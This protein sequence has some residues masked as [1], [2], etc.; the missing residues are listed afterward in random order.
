M[1][2]LI[3]RLVSR[4]TGTDDGRPKDAYPYVYVEHDGS[5]RELNGDERTDLEADDKGPDRPYVK[6]RYGKR[7]GR[8]DLSGYLRRWQLP[9]RVRVYPA[10]LNLGR[11]ERE[12]GADR[13]DPARPAASSGRDD[14][15][16]DVR[17]AQ[18]PI[19]L[20][21]GASYQ[22]AFASVEEFLAYIE[23]MDVL[24]GDVDAFDA[25]G[26]RLL[27]AADSATDG[28]RVT[29]LR[30]DPDFLHYA[31]AASLSLARPDVA[32]TLGP[33]AD[34]ADLVNA[35]VVRTHS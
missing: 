5:A 23:A 34:I 25:V 33:D 1:P 27:L 21:E 35:W 8:G 16:L 11:R 24:N 9:A 22:N 10:P 2:S 32:R 6:W 26:N 14:S 4:L 12:E 17:D 7:N 19:L 3:G 31:L 28:V 18:P 15:A 13:D 30:P 20:L 29:G